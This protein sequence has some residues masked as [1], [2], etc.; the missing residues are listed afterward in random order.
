M[1]R[2]EANQQFEYKGKNFN[3]KIEKN[4]RAERHIGGDRYHRLTVND[5]G[6]SQ[7][8]KTYEVEH[9]GLSSKIS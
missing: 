4:I 1:A 3:I 5:M 7:Y 9:R 6:H 2:N 8:Y